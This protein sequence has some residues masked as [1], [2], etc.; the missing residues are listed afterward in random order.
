MKKK[1]KFLSK[2]VI[3]SFAVLSMAVSGF[4]GTQQRYNKITGIINAN[5]VKIY[6]EIPTAGST[7]TVIQPSTENAEEQI[8]T[9]PQAFKNIGT[10]DEA[11]A[12]NVTLVGYTTS[13]SSGIA[14]MTSVAPAGSYTMTT[15]RAYMAIQAGKAVAEDVSGD[16]DEAFA[17]RF[18]GAPI[19][20]IVRNTGN[21]YKK[22]TQP[23]VTIKPGESMPVRVTGT[24]NQ[25]VEWASSDKI[26]VTPMFKITPNMTAK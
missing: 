2:L 24:V 17:A 1:A 22:V 9:T 12:Y 18:V 26:Q 7:T 23:Y 10:G 4:A 5:D 19:N 13:V 14:L 11:I 20:F 21:V 25:K 16:S 15:K 8:T 6:V 3:T